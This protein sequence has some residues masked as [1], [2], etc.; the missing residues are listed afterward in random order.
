M[1]TLTQT[2]PMLT[3]IR[4]EYDTIVATMWKAKA[5]MYSVAA[6]LGQIETIT[7]EKDNELVWQWH[8]GRGITFPNAASLAQAV[9]GSD[10]MET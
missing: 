10:E 6:R 7:V 4:H 5:C 8:Y 3:P 1:F 2:G 9:E